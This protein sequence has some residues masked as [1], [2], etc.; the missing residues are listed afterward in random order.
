MY[1]KHRSSCRSPI[2]GRKIEGKGSNRPVGLP[3]TKDPG[4]MNEKELKFHFCALGPG[5]CAECLI[6]AYG[7]EYVRRQRENGNAEE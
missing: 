2:S 4:R 5:K 7:R 3:G 6:C 1:K